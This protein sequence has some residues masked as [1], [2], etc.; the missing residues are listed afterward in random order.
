LAE[1]GI[2]RWT[3]TSREAPDRLGAVDAGV[4]DM[5]HARRFDR[6]DLS[7]LRQRFAEVVEESSAGSEQDGYH[8]DQQ[9][10]EQA[11]REV[12]LH[13]AGAAA[14][15][16][17]LLA[18]GCSCLLERRVDPVGDEMEGRSFELEW[19][20]GM[21][22]QDE[23]RVVVRRLVSPVALPVLPPRARPTAEHVP[24]H[25]R[26]ADPPRIPSAIGVL[27]LTSPACSPPW[28]S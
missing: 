16:N 8:G 11:G 20:A 17:I 12:L 24:A 14:D 25:D 1:A 15:R 5:R 23:D 19:L 18:R 26:G 2:R 22:S 9:L 13:G 7:E 10:V 27:A 3:S 6:L 21:V 28:V 4:P